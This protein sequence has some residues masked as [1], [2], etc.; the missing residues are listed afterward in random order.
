MVIVST[1]GALSARAASRR[2]LEPGLVIGLGGHGMPVLGKAPGELEAD[3]SRRL[4][5]RTPPIFEG[6]KYGQFER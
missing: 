3:S 4:E 5:G 2:L 6:A 1:L